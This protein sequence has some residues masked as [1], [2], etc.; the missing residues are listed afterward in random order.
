MN[1]NE[2]IQQFQQ[3]AQHMLPEAA[4]QKAYNRPLE[5]VRLANAYAVES[6]WE[7]EELAQARNME[8]ATSRRQVEQALLRRE[9]DSLLIRK[10][11]GIKRS[12]LESLLSK[13]TVRKIVFLEQ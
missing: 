3:V 13:C 6:G 4:R 2:M 12:E 1:N 11:A 10:S 5:T 9:P 7:T 8:T